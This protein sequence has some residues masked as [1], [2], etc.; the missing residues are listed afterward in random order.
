MNEIIQKN[1]LMFSKLKFIVNEAFKL[2]VNQNYDLD[3]DFTKNLVRNAFNENTSIENHIVNTYIYYLDNF[4]KDK[5]ENKIVIGVFIYEIVYSV[6]NAITYKN[7]QV[8]ETLKNLPFILKSSF[9]DDTLKKLETNDKIRL[10]KIINEYFLNKTM[11]FAP[12]INSDIHRKIYLNALNSTFKNKIENYKFHTFFVYYLV[13]YYENEIF[14]N[15]T[16]RDYFN[17]YK[18]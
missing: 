6:I 17:K 3:I 18:T 1:N 12:E 14:Q 9:G 8:L 13:F 2:I 11:E 7:P 10:T 15:S 5:E 4:S 16:F